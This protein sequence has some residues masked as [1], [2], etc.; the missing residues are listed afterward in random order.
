MLKVQ[1]TGDHYP[2]LQK[3]LS[4]TTRFLKALEDLTFMG[5]IL[6]RSFAVTIPQTVEVTDGPGKH[7]EYL[8]QLGAG[9][10]LLY[11]D[12]SKLEN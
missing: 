5:P 8:Q 11:P 4:P 6:A 10:V 2:S 12:G 1:Q 9:K 7:K 3:S